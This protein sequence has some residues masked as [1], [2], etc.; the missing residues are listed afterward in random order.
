MIRDMVLKI[1]EDIWPMML[2]FSI[3]VI[4]LRTV[5]LYKNKEKFILYKEVLN[6]GFILYVICLFRVVSFQDVSWSTSNFIPFK[7]MLRYDFGSEL[8]FRNVIGNMIMFIPYGFFISYV[9]KN[10]K[11]IVAII[12]TFIVSLTIEITQSLI[13]RVFDIDDII[14]NVLGG[15]VG[16]VFYYFANRLKFKGLLQ[17]TIFYNII[18]VLILVLIILYLSG[19]LYV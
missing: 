5:Y 12:L 15:S 17:K 7:E 19:V 14:L 10:E 8:F 13:G 18:I 6:F 1:F 11:P 9:L 4:S 2:I 16:F 3:I